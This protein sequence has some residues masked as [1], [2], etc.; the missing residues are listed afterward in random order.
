MTDRAGVVPF[1]RSHLAG[2][3]ELERLCFSSPWSEKALELYLADGVAFVATGTDGQILGYGGMLP[4]GD[5]GEILNLAVHPTARQQGL[6]GALLDALLGEADRRRLVQIALEVR[7][8][9]VGA[10]ALY[11]SRGFET[12]GVRRRFYTAPVEDAYTMIRPWGNVDHRDFP[13]R[14]STD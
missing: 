10:I 3:A 11:R 14:D 8:S 6:G 9:N 2:V 12:V 1:D 5:E 4:S 13:L 7:I